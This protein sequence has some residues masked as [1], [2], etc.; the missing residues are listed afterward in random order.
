MVNWNDDEVKKFLD[1]WSCHSQKHEMQASAAL[2]RLEFK[3]VE[4]NDILRKSYRLWPK[5]IL[6]YSRRYQQGKDIGTLFCR[7]V[8]YKGKK[9]WFLKDGNHRYIAVI[10][11]GEEKVRIA[12]DPKNKI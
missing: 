9:K 4:V 5:R 1:E 7:A 8:I 11:N 12:Y 6:M 10:A 3:E 2:D